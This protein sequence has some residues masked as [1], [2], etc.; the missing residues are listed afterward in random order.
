MNSPI[1]YVYYGICIPV[2]EPGTDALKSL[3]RYNTT[4]EIT[5]RVIKT[6]TADGLELDA[7]LVTPP[8]RTSKIVIHFHGK[9]GDFLQ[10]H[11]IWQMAADYPKAGYAFMTASHRGKSY[12]ADILRKSATGYEYT[13]LGSAFDIFEESV[14]DID[15]WV[16]EA[17]QLGYTEV[18]LQQH[19]TPQKIAWYVHTQKPRQVVA[20]ILL[21]PAD[22][23][24]AFEKYVPD[25]GKNLTL[26]KDMI[27]HG[28]SK[29]LMPVP[30]WSNC[31]VSAATFFNWG[32]PD[33]PIQEFN[34]AHPEEGFRYFPGITLPVLAVLGDCDF[35]VGEPAQKCLDILREKSRSRAFGSR[36]IT[37]AAHG[38]LGHESE[39]T[40]AVI[41]WLKE[42]LR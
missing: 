11:F 3:I 4:M 37:G 28:K 34:Y 1:C 36:L 30:L 26:A 8:K 33:S 2:K 31:P 22:I 13:Q 7:V 15:A 35:A 12:M 21:S 39:L 41:G 40:A 16:R 24:F 18:V 6:T 17:G 5:G 10:N 29:E 27:D 14:N 19:S 38:Y 32:N 20:L 9:E 23:R 25:Y 42:T